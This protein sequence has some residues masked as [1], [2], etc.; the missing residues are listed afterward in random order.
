MP[1]IFQY[2]THEE[3]SRY[4][5]DLFQLTYVKDILEHHAIQNEVSVLDDM[6]NILAS[7]TRSLTNPKN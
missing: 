5:K 4:L 1:Y 7:S 6:L 3:K 2:E